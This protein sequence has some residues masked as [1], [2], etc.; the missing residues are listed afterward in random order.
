MPIYKGNNLV[1][2]IYRGETPVQEVYRGASLVFGGD[3]P[4]VPTDWI[5]GSTTIPN[6]TVSFEILGVKRNKTSDDEGNFAYTP[7][8]PSEVT[9]L[10]NFFDFSNNQTR[11]KTLD[12]RG[13]GDK[14]AGV[15]T[16]GYAFRNLKT[17]ESL[18]ISNWVMSSL[19][20]MGAAFQNCNVLAELDV[21][22][23][24]VTAVTTFSTTFNGCNT[25]AELD[26][27]NWSTPN[28]TNMRGTFQNCSSLER[29]ILGPGWD[30]SNVTANNAFG[31]FFN[32]TALNYIKCPQSFKDF[33]QSNAS[34]INLPGNL[35]E[36]GSCEWDIID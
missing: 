29:L 15:T 35:A 36:G 23:L 32:C 22:G 8:S 34:S 2:A 30:I 7:T 20:T 19:T 16:M 6:Q 17:L 3:E 33:I 14:V 11:V 21:S 13:M 9:S 28:V 4:D 26:L 31:I 27:S 12:L 1:T 10:I 24:D 25:L 5:K 18:D